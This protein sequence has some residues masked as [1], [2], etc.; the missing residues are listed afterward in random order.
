MLGEYQVD[1]FP[2]EIANQ[3]K[4]NGCR[5]LY[6]ARDWVGGWAG[7]YETVTY[8]FFTKKQVE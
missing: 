2:K 1:G 5:I 6:E 8:D 4:A 3:L 7:D